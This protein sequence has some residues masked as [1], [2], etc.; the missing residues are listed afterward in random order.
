MLAIFFLIAVS[1]FIPPFWF[2]TIGYVIYL[3]TTK[4]QRRN[5]VIMNEV[6]QSNALK[7]E[8]VILD[9]LYFNSAKSF[10]VDH[11]ATLS[12][13]INDPSD[14]TLVVELN[15]D[16]ENYQITLQRWD[17]DETLLSVCTAAKAKENQKSISD[18]DHLLFEDSA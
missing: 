14:D 16:G 10:A 6:M 13:R 11:G 9:Y 5:K 7:R 3:I 17:K 15:I 18:E 8:Q 2:V 12:K 1:I 4:K